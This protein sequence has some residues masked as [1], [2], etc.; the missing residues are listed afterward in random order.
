MEL[1]KYWAKLLG[2]ENPHA[3]SFE[4]QISQLASH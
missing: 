1:V 4:E 2:D 3:V